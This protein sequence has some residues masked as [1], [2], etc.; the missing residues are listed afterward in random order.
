[1]GKVIL[2]AAMSVDGYWAEPGGQ[3]IYP[4]G[5]L[6][7]SAIMAELIRTTGAVVMSRNSYAM[8]SD[9]DWYVDNY[10]YQVPIF[11]VSADPPAQ[12][13]KQSD[14]LTFTFVRKGMEDAVRRAL[15]AAGGRNVMVIGEATAAQQVLNTGLLNELILRVVP[16]VLGRGVRLFSDF[17]NRIELNRESVVE[18][19]STTHLRFSVLRSCR[20][21]GSDN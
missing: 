21:L 16:I 2:D 5:E 10:E 9:P 18:T 20:T 12:L 3:S 8:A 14:R 4:I 11:V 15:N 13:P 1:M 7:G 19:S 6:R 17:G